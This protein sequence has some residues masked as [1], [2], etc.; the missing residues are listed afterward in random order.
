MNTTTR[1]TRRE[2]VGTAISTVAA[3]A[4]KRDVPLSVEPKSRFGRDFLPDW[5]L[6]KQITLEFAREMPEEHYNFKPTPELRSFAE[7]MLHI[8]ESNIVNIA[9]FVKGEK[10]P[11]DD[12]SAY[13][14]KAD[15]IAYLERALDYVAEA[16]RELTDDHA[17]ETVAFPEGSRPRRKIF[18]YTRDHMTHHRGQTVPYYRLKGVVPPRWRG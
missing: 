5:E 11:N 7:H 14:T 18:W 16:A 4:C 12:L 8:A 1:I 10:P 9:R 13:K 17:D 2:L 3:V 15:I 6:S